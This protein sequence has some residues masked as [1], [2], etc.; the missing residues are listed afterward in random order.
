MI[1]DLSNLG[2]FL[3]DFLGALGEFA[4][5]VAGARSRAWS[6][7][8][9]T[10]LDVDDRTLRPENLTAARLAIEAKHEL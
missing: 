9:P 3:G 6:I 4:E 7:S 5:R 10:S 8:R 1:A 2:T